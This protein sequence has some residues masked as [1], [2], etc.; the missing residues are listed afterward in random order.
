M[1]N[2]KQIEAFYWTLKLGTLQRAATQLFLTQSAVT[3]RLQA[4]ENQAYL[5]LFEGSGPKAH[6]SAKGAELL[7]A[8]EGLITSLARLDGLR[9]A[10]R[11]TLRTVR[12]GLTELVTVT[13]FSDFAARV[14]AVHPEVALHPDVDLSASLQ[15]KLLDGDLDLVVIPQD[16]VTPAMAAIDLQSVEFTWL[17]PASLA[18]HERSLSLKELAQWPI[19]VQGA[20]SGITQRCEQLFARSGIEFNRVYGSNSLFAL[21]ALIRAGVGISCLPR[22]LFGD[23]IRRG[24]LQEMVLD[25]PPESVNYQLAF[26][27]HGHLGLTDSL[28]GLA[29]Q[30]AAA[31]TN[32]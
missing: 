16:Y 24:E 25:A 32:R 20:H 9:G 29:S 7:E 26:L 10:S 23:E 2:R 13:W 22:G 11:H 14:K 27:K 28:A 15:R 4:L 5:P 30:C 18:L 8:C 3:K 31:H 19:I 17:A 12:M 21:V 6:L 1:I